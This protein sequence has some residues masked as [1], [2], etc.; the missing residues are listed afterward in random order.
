MIDRFSQMPSA[1]KAQARWQRLGS[2]SI[3]CMLVHPDWNSQRPAPIVLWMHG[4]TAHKELDPGRYLRWLRAG[5]GVCAIDLP[6]H[7]ERHDPELQNPEF[8]FNVVRQMIQEIDPLTQALLELNVFDPQRMAIGG[9]SAGGMATL[10]RLCSPHPFRCAAVE[11]TTGS[12]IH[13]RGRQMFHAVGSDEID[14]FNPLAHLN[15]WR[16]IPLQAI[17]ARFDQWVPIEGQIQF[18]Q[19][20]QKQ[21]RDPSLIEFIQYDHTGAPYEHIGFGTRA[22]DAKNA[23]RDFLQR[24]L[25]DRPPSL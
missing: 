6:G 14:R 10:A 12:W 25:I 13:Q 7:G 19:A 15:A 21:Y 17:H 1:L 5:I 8:S 23:Q 9:I 22:A 3:P 24:W 11:A 16:E 18:I 4:R 2:S 20:L